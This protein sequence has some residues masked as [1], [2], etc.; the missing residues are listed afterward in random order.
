MVKSGF[1][2][3]GLDNIFVWITQKI[4]TF[5]FSEALLLRGVNAQNGFI[6]KGFILF[7]TDII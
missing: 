2:Q 1:S 4:Q 5:G 3:K 7:S 6:R